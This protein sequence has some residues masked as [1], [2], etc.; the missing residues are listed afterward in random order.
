MLDS[1][2]NDA[3]W[4]DIQYSIYVRKRIE[5]GRR[6]A[7]E[8]KLIGDSPRYAAALVDEAR[9]AARA[10]RMFPA[11]GRM[12][13]ELNDDSVRELFVKKYRL[14]YELRPDRVVIL[15]FIHG[16]RQFPPSLR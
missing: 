10:L 16:A 14:V 3:N 4:E 15:A 12:A 7:D 8:G 2:P 6:E 5:R 11:R 9:P 1:L 13:P